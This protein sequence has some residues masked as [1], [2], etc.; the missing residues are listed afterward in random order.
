MFYFLHLKNQLIFF[1]LLCTTSIKKTMC[2]L[3]CEFCG[4][5]QKHLCNLCNAIDDHLRLNC[6]Q[7]KKM[8]CVFNCG[9]PSCLAG[10]PH[11]CKYCNAYNHHR[12]VDCKR[13]P[14]R[15]ATSVF[16]AVPARSTARSAAPAHFAVPAATPAV[17]ARS[18]VPATSAKLS[19]AKAD[20]R[21]LQAKLQPSRRSN[22]T[23]TAAAVVVISGHY[24]LIQR[25]ASWLIPNYGTP[26]GPIDHYA[27]PGGSIDQG[28]SPLTTAFREA[29]EEAGLT[30]NAS[31]SKLLHTMPSNSRCQTFIVQYTGQSMQ[32]PKGKAW[33]ECDSIPAHVPG[34]DAT[35]GHKW[36]EAS[37][38][39]DLI[40]Q[41]QFLP[42]AEE[43]IFKA[44]ELM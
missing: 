40:K 7:A 20:A 23:P 39:L 13:N 37:D 27:T 8:P 5:N 36:M 43:A 30:L 25:R 9:H 24:L 17:P 22:V 11:W 33:H 19:Q 38:V 41:G 26:G 15:S 31:N 4:P 32:F 42:A 6:P 28:E 18:A 1:Y 2:K 35:Y 3:N 44:I 12:S 16:S 14:A 34:I 10:N 29:Y 21:A